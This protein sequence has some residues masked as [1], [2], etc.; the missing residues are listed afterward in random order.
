[1]Q[2]PANPPKLSAPIDLERVRALFTRTERVQ[3]SDFLRREVSSRMFDRL[4]L[5]K[6]APQRVLDA[7]C[8]AGADLA[9]LQKSYPA[10]QILGLDAAEAQLRAARGGIAQ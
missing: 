10:A 4:E 6:I 3:S 1:M 7:G 8:G 9:L 5:I 2:V